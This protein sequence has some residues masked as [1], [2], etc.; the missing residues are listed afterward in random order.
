VEIYRF[1]ISDKNANSNFIKWGFIVKKKVLL[2]SFYALPCSRELRILFAESVITV[3]GPNI[4]TTPA[5]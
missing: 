1:Q 4:P 5:S 2:K 3:P